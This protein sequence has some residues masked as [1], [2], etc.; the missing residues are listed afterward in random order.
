MALKIFQTLFNKT[1]EVKQN[2]LLMNYVEERFRGLTKETLYLK[3]AKY[4]EDLKTTDNV[5][6][7]Q[8]LKDAITTV[9]NELDKM[10][11]A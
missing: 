10:E 1:P 5:Y 7:Q 6:K 8:L 4:E 2:Q 3:L 9:N 11:C